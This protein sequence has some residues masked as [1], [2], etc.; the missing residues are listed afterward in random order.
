MRTTAVLLATVLGFR[1]FSVLYATQPASRMCQGM[2][3][4][5]CISPVW[6]KCVTLFLSL[7]GV[8]VLCP[9]GACLAAVMVLRCTPCSNP[10][11]V[12]AD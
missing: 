3:C 6:L 9:Y 10:E 7:F 4:S 1:C 2:S 5:T 12:F 8:V 11:L